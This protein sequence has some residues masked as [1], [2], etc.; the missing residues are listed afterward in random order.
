MIIDV[1]NHPDWCGH[2][3]EKYIENMDMYGIDKTWLLSWE[4]PHD[5]YDPHYLS[6]C[7]PIIS[8][9]WGPI[10]FERCISYME[11]APERFI[12]GY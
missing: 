9:P 8:A 11:R 2:N 3:L 1:H 7:P 6:K 12:L 4:A 10:P 5:E